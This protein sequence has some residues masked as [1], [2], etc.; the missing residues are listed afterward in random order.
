MGLA[1]PSSAQY[2]NGGGGGGREEK[3]RERVEGN[4]RE[5]GGTRGKDVMSP[6]PPIGKFL[7]L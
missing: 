7:D 4:G 3:R 6:E 2:S 5:G 1:D